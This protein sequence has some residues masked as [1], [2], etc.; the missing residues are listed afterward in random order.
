MVSEGI[1]QASCAALSG[2]GS[3]FSFCH[4]DWIC[5]W[6]WCMLVRQNLRCWCV[7]TCV[8][9]SSLASLAGGL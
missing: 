6:C 3:L 7:G 4:M 8:P 9:L 5:L 2:G 1:V